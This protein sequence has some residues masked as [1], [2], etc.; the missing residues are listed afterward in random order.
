[1]IL[2][3]D[4][5]SP[6]KST[7]R[8]RIR[9]KTVRQAETIDDPFN[10]GVRM[11][12]RRAGHPLSVRLQQVD[13]SKRIRLSRELVEAQGRLRAAGKD[14][15]SSPSDIAILDERFGAAL[16]RFYEDTPSEIEEKAASYVSGWGGDVF[17]EQR[18]EG[19]PPSIKEVRDDFFGVFG[20]E[21]D[22][23]DNV[24]PRF[25]D[26]TTREF[27]V[28]GDKRLRVAARIKKEYVDS[29]EKMLREPERA[30][31]DDAASYLQACVEWESAEAT[32]RREAK[33][34]KLES[35]YKEKLAK[36]GVKETPWGGR[37]IRQAMA[38]VIID[39]SLRL[40]REYQEKTVN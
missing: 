14:V 19:S 6:A 4:T 21:D 1:M 20:N 25:M 17:P 36:A 18:L 35:R 22:E 40:E 3:D 23:S 15:P 32:S 24:L 2:L 29:V 34:E 28:S 12:I 8:N 11:R 30:D 31:F 9:T 38:L 39:E 5:P 10:F 33:L 27:I 26:S 13:A 16:A 37:P 7:V